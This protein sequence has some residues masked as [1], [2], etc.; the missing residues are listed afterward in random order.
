MPENKTQSDERKPHFLSARRPNKRLRRFVL[1]AWIHAGR[2]EVV[3]WPPPAG[4]EDYGR[5]T[6]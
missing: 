3:E 1:L 4:F 2:V 5:P 6:L